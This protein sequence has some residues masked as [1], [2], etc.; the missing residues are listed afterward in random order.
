ME[1][2]KKLIHVLG[3]YTTFKNHNDQFCNIF[4]KHIIQGNKI[5]RAK[6]TFLIYLSMGGRLQEDLLKCQHRVLNA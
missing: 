4:K 2:N 3:Y 6:Y 1:K 5:R